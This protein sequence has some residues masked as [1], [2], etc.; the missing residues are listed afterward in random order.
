MYVEGITD[1]DKLKI[2][3]AICQM[4]QSCILKASNL[5]KNISHFK[6]HFVCSVALLLISTYV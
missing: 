5:R 3:Y 6:S 2:I 4:Y 1:L